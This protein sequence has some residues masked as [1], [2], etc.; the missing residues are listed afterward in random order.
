MTTQRATL[1]RRFYGVLAAAIA[2]FSL[3]ALADEVKVTL[4]GDNEV[5]PVNTKAFGGGTITIDPNLTVSGGITTSGIAGTMAHIHLAA[6]GVNGPVI[7]PLS[8]SGDSGWTVPPGSKLTDA[9]YQAYKAGELYVNVHSDAHKGGEI[10]GQLSAPM[11][12]AMKSG[13]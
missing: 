4:S 12:A 6:K 2:A 9:Q 13:Y 10:R 11:G 1:R 8:K 3:A 7:I 5:P